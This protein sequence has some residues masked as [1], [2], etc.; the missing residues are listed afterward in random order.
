MSV[1]PVQ[2]IN[3]GGSLDALVS[4]TVRRPSAEDS[5]AP[6][7]SEASLSPQEQPQ[8]LPEARTLQVSA[9]FGENH[10]VIYRIVDKTTGK[11]VEQIPPDQFVD[12][13]GTLRELSK[14]ERP[15]EPLALDVRA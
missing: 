5:D 3:A 6:R 7:S 15:K 14:E 9:A 4:D 1:D 13:S 10:I 2:G 11:L 8:T 12:V